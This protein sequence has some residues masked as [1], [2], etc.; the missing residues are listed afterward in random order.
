MTH[1]PKDDRIADG[2]VQLCRV[3]LEK[4]RVPAAHEHNRITLPDRPG[5]GV[6][7]DRDRLV[8]YKVAYKTTYDLIPPQG[9]Y[10]TEA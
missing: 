1:R 10:G 2:S 9:F 5:T 7:F 3:P 6:T 8:R 4:P